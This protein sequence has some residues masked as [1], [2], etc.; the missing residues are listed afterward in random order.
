MDEDKIREL[1][2]NGYSYTEISKL[3]GRSKK[4]IHSKAKDIKLNMNGKKRYFKK[5]K[6]IKKQIL[7]QPANLTIEKVRIIGHLF[8]DGCLSNSG[9]NYM[10]KYISSTRELINR[11]ISDMKEVYG[12][13]PSALEIFKGKNVSSYY[14]VSFKSK[15]AFEDLKKYSSSYSTSN[16]SASIPKEIMGSNRKIKLEFLET[17]FEDE[18]SISHNG[19]IM[20]D[21]KSERIIKQIIF[22]LREFGLNFKLSK[23]KEYSCFM[24]KIYLPKNK[25]NLRLFFKLGLFEK[26]RVTRGINLGK[27][28]K[29]VLNKILNEYK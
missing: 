7:S 13:S 2:K 8:F 3:T 24:W 29:D 1:R 14:K 17:F 25:E 20:G 15:K 16:I 4:F 18:G 21:L 9:Y 19:R 22:L 28:K 12:L 26:A 10:I 27:R 6:G 23:Y 11:F 5:V